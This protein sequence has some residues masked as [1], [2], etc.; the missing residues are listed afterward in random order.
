[1]PRTPSIID[2][3]TLT[4]RLPSSDARWLTHQGK[5]VGNTALL[6]RRL[7]DDARTFYG[8]PEPIREVLAMDAKRKGTHQREYIIELLT[9]RYAELLQEK[10]RPVQPR[11]AK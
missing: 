4:V 8:M 1:M 6:L 2:A 9:H 3:V 5:E 7:V 10:F 11:R